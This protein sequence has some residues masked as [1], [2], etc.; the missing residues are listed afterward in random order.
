MIFI[1]STRTFPYQFLVLFSVIGHSLRFVLEISV[2]TCANAHF[3]LH[4]VF[5]IFIK[6]FIFWMFHGTV[7]KIFEDRNT[8]Q[9][10]DGICRLRYLSYT[11]QGSRQRIFPALSLFNVFIFNVLCLWEC[12]ESGSPL[13]LIWGVYFL[14]NQLVWELL[15]HEYCVHIVTFTGGGMTMRRSVQY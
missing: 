10:V 11:S 4:M 5:V 12:L 9:R 3:R 14:R 6:N 13:V 7:L 1:F 2:Q 15:Y 8:H